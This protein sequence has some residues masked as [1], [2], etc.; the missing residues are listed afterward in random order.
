MFPTV[1]DNSMREEFVSCPHSFWLSYV[2]GLTLPEISVH[3]HAG[4]AYA[5]GLEEMRR[6]F[7]TDGKSIDDSVALGARALIEAYGEFVPP[8]DSNKTLSRM[9]GALLF[10]A[11]SFPLDQDWVTPVIGSNGA[12]LEYTFAIPLPI[13]NPDTGEPII[14]AGRFDMLAQ[15]M[16]EHC[17]YDDKTA[18]QLGKQWTKKWRLNSQFTGYSWA[19]REYGNH[20]KR[21]IVRG[22]SILKESYGK[23]Q[24]I[25]YRTDAIIDR[26]YKQLLMEIRQM[27]SFYQSAWWP[28]NQSDS[29][30]A[31]GG[32]MFLDSCEKDDPEQWLDNFVIRQYN[33]L[34]LEN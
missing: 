14:Y 9:V 21:I 33:P 11:D 3:L 2:R 8:D 10:Y 16:G 31:Y 4:I 26:W 32:C 29:C 7:Y 1:I 20:A 13:N 6:A 15:T 24:A 25:V 5:K 17:I 12:S 30:A 19:T 28:R 18:S 27:I 22:I 23:E 34:N